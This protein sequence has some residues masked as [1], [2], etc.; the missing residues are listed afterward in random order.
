MNETLLTRLREKGAALS[1][2][3]LDEMYRR[4]FWLERFGDSGHRR[5]EEDAHH[6]ISYVT[7]AIAGG[8][9]A[10]FA[11]YA[12]WLQSVLTTRGMCTRHLDENF[13]LLQQVLRTELGDAD[14]AIEVLQRGREA[15]VYAEGPERELQLAGPAIADHLAAAAPG[16]DAADLADHLSYLADSVAV[17]RTLL[18]ANYA[19][20]M[21]GFYRRR[22]SEAREQA[23]LEA[24]GEAV[25]H[26]PH[27]S[28]ETRHAARSTL[29]KAIEELTH[30]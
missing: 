23:L 8:D 18:F 26:T 28:S 17:K 20:W 19:K 29:S 6:H 2:R 9:P 12:K 24:I 11:G 1:I 25:D 30:G 3:A 15:I 14:V 13:A 16:A 27:L 5:A 22:K 10:V 21:D 4:P 7:E